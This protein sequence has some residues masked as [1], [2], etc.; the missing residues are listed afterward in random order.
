MHVCR[1]RFLREKEYIRMNIM[2]TDLLLLNNKIMKD[3]AENQTSVAAQVPSTVQPQAG[4]KA[5][6]FQGI[7]NLMAN[8]ELAR[9]VGVNG[10]NNGDASEDKDAAKSYVAPFSSNIA[11]Q[12]KFKTIAAATLLAATAALTSCEKYYIETPPAENKTEVTVTVT[13]Q[14]EM[15]SLINLM[16]NYFTQALLQGQMNYELWAQYMEDSNAWR[17]QVNEKLDNMTFILQSIESL[18]YDANGKLDE[19]NALTKTYIAMLEDKGYSYS[20]A[21]QIITQ[22]LDK[23]I[24]ALGLI[25]QDLGVLIAQGEAAAQERALQNDMLYDIMITGQATKEGIDALNENMTDTRNTMI[26][27]AQGFAEQLNKLGSDVTDAIGYLAQQNNCTREQ[28]I[29]SLQALGIKIDN[30]TA[31]QYIT[32]GML[33]GQLAGIQHELQRQTRELKGIKLDMSDL[34]NYAKEVLEVTKSIEGRIGVFMEDFATFAQQANDA[35]ARLETLASKANVTLDEINA[36]H[37]EYKA[38]IEQIKGIVLQISQDTKS[39]SEKMVTKEDFLKAMGIQTAVLDRAL[40]FLGYTV[41]EYST[42]NAD[43]IIAAFKKA[44]NGQNELIDK[45]GK[46]LDEIS[47]KLG[48]LIIDGDL[49]A[50]KEL[51]QG[52][53]DKLSAFV[54]DWAKSRD[55]F[56][57]ALAQLQADV[58]AIREEEKFQ[59]VQLVKLN[60]GIRGLS[61]D[62]KVSTS[63]LKKIYEK[64]ENN[65]PLTKE[66][67]EAIAQRLNCSVNASLSQIKALLKTEIGIEKGQSEKLDS[68]ADKLDNLGTIS[69]NIL[70]DL[71]N[72]DLSKLDTIITKIEALTTAVNNFACQFNNYAK[73]AL[74]AYGE[75]IDIL[76]GI[77]GDIGNVLSKLNTLIVQAKRANTKLS[78][79]DTNLTLL[80]NQVKSLETKLG[81]Q[82][83]ADELDTVLSKHDAENQAF[84]AD[85]IKNVN[86]NPADYSSLEAYLKAIYDVLVTG[87]KETNNNLVNIFEWLKNHPDRAQDIID[88]INNKEFNVIV[89]CQHECDCNNKWVDESEITVIS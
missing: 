66:D 71:E 43:R 84:Y 44:I 59:S 30:N 41:A 74:K 63:Y 36:A 6:M 24:E 27:I 10:E 56:M 39:I 21:I 85:L 54:E 32:A 80:M 86:I 12:G 72:I 60:K 2:K 87:Q 76:K 88:A 51:L 3:D 45:N 67:M 33:Q 7:Q 20:Q 69:Q 82:L 8:P 70:L 55:A 46:K 35:W 9:E 31:A 48:Q 49:S 13:N 81:R 28:V 65:E 15:A 47:D 25:H 52:I 1:Y 37:K 73:A 22:G 11:F 62:L 17:Q 50:I 14:N 89:T 78:S 42:W 4:M 26:N 83:T 5:L 34:K 61:S 18:M 40:Q 58:K 68:I 29:K 16:Q 79:I 57:T 64:I 23:V 77:K 75:E 19:N 38:A 53:Y